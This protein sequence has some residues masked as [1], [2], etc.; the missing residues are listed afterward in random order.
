MYQIQYFYTY[1]LLLLLHQF[2]L[3]CNAVSIASED[4]Q[5]NEAKFSPGLLVIS[6][7]AFR[8]EYFN[9]SVTPYMNELR[10]NGSTTD[11]LKNEFPT[12]TF[13]NHHSIATG[14]YPSVHGVLANSVYDLK[15][16]KKLDYGYEL[17]HYNENIIPIWVS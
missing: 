3:I 5:T 11:Y 7:D 10:K 2:M 8:P 1:S 16:Q 15:L 4:P 13:V 6:Y 14:M 12:K 9:R 17:F